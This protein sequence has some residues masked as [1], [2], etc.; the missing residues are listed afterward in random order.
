MKCMQ[1]LPSQKSI[2][3][4]EKK[5]PLMKYH[6]RK[7]DKLTEE[8]ENQKYQLK[9]GKLNKNI[10]TDKPKQKQKNLERKQKDREQNGELIQALKKQMKLIDILKRQKA[11]I[12]TAKILSFTKEDL[13]KILELSENSD[14]ISYRDGCIYQRV[15]L[16]SVIYLS[17]I[18]I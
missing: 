4:I 2:S 15:L 18:H 16:C 9:E 13:V 11:H 6:K 3:T 10:K 7:L 1:K 8:L 17:L 12:E 5:M 14:K